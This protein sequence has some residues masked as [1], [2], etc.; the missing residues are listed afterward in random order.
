MCCYALIIFSI[1]CTSLI[2]C[3][4]IPEKPGFDRHDTISL[5]SIR[6]RPE[7]SKEYHLDK[8]K[9]FIDEQIKKKRHL[10]K[11]IAKNIIIFLGDGMSV[12][13]IAAARIYAG[14]TEKSLSFERFPHVA[15]SKTYCVDHQIAD[16]ACT[17]TGTE[18]RIK[19]E[20]KYLF[21]FDFTAKD[22]L[23]T[24]YIHRW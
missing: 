13:T 24:K 14:G 12:P 22:W 8:A 6:Y 5:N 17:A 10:N 3:A 23:N 15:M 20:I 9:K 7:L 11:N 18:R 1:L 21:F 2:K 4:T 19:R 16:S